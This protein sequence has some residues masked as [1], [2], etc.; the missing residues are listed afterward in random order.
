LDGESVEVFEFDPGGVVRDEG[1]GAGVE[2]VGCEIL[3]RGHFCH[4]GVDGSVVGVAGVDVG[5]GSV[6][7]TG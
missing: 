7:D 6:S 5:G 3:G 4:E 2:P 1:C